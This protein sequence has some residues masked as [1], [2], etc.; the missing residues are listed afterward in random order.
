MQDRL[1]TKVKTAEKSVP[2]EDR[3]IA[4]LEDQIKKEKRAR[5]QDDEMR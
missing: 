4:E 2:V 5:R 3:N 1:H